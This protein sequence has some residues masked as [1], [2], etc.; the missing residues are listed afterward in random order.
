MK[1]SP[2]P[3]T[4]VLNS[5]SARIALALNKPMKVDMSLKK[6][7]NQTKHSYDYNQTWMNQIPAL[8]NS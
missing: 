2:Y 4:Y 6:K 7:R 3:L 1:H 8:S 5:S